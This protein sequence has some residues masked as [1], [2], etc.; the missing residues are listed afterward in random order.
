MTFLTTKD[1]NAPLRGS[2]RLRPRSL[3]LGCL[4]AALLLR[5]RSGRNV[6]TSATMNT[7]AMIRKPSR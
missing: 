4:Y 5:A 6:G 1:A 2:S 7:L 3:I